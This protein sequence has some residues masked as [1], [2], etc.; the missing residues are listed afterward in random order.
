MSIARRRGGELRVEADRII[1]C[2]GIEEKY[3]ESSRP[4]IRS[5]AAGGLAAVNRL[6]TGFS[7][8]SSGALIDARGRISNRLFT[9]GPTRSGDL[10]ETVAVPEIRQ[11]A[12]N[13][14]DRILAP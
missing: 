6:G 1:N 3:T 10:I 7:A 13:L 5:L 4:L 2:T 11:Q 12:R 14:A 8:D 9:L